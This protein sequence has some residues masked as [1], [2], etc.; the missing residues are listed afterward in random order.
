MKFSIYAVVLS[1]LLLVSC[2]ASGTDDAESEKAR[3]GEARFN[4]SYFNK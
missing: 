2:A 1:L 4:E 3:F